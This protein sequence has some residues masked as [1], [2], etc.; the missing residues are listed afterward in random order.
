MSEARHLT[1]GKLGTFEFPVGWYVYVGSAHGSGGLRAR[2]AHHLSS[3]AKPHWHIDYLRLA[4]PLWSVWYRASETVFE[5]LWATQLLALPGAEMPVRR[6]GASDC[7]CATHLIHFRE[8][9]DLE[10]FSKSIGA[11]VM[12]QQIQP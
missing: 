5:H 2:L 6:F 9:P 8:Y 3:A 12:H 10:A 1:V 7:T 4:A 11:E